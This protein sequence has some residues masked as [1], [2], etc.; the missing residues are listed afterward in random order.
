MLTAAAFIFV[1]GILIFI[2]E[3]GH[4]LVAKKAGIRVEKFSLGFP[5]NIVAKKFGDT[6]YCI[7]IIPL[8]GYV[9]MAGD[10]PLEETEGAP[11]EFP[12]KPIGHRAA[13]IFAGPFMNYLLA[14]VLL[15]GLYFFAGGRILYDEN[16]ILVGEVKPDAPADKAGLKSGDQIIALNG[17]PYTSMDS[18]RIRINAEVEKA[19]ELTWIHN[20]DTITRQITTMAEPVRNAEGGLDTVGIIGFAEKSLG[21]QQYSFDQAAIRAF[22]TTHVLVAETFRFIEK[23]VTGK[24]SVKAV[25][26]PIFIATQ[27][28]EQ[29][30]RGA[31]SLFTFMAL[32]S[33]NLAV[34]NVLPIPVLDGG[35]L[36][37]LLIEKIRGGPL[38]MK[39]RTWAQQ[40]GLVIIL[41]LIVLVTYN[42]ILREIRGY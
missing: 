7:G 28:G 16:R 8:G 20:G 6:T 13:V 3:L 27:S 11:D 19:I 36:I 23:F 35:H 10:N 21:R 5:P 41:G 38:S 39:A 33:V 24:I 32:L 42:D 9:K 37:F 15:F 25:G 18:L 14:M 30:R 31:Y 4:F 22:V 26:G 29:A 34:L 1:L 40:I 17:H 12:S 2:H